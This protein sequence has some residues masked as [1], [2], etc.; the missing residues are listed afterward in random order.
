[1]GAQHYKASDNSGMTLCI[2]TTGQTVVHFY[3]Q[4]FDAKDK[5]VMNGN[6]PL[7]PIP[8]CSS[9]IMANIGEIA[10]KSGFK[11]KLGWINKSPCDCE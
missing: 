9:P 5:I 10:D 7:R 6:Q 1:M 3:W 2:N 4:I 8:F 11:F